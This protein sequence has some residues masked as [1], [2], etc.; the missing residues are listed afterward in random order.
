MGREAEEPTA[1]RIYDAI[2]TAT[3]FSFE[4][5]G[6][7][8]RGRNGVLDLGRDDLMHCDGVQAGMYY[9]GLENTQKNAFMDP[10]YLRQSSSPHSPPCFLLPH[11][12][13][14]PRFS[15]L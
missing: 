3:V 14:P 13:L 7:R 15:Q 9:T 4:L 8:H 12:R 5:F 10:N 1:T 2:V 11:L 6:G